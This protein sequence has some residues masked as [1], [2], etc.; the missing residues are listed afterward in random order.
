MEGVSTA[1]WR[2]TTGPPLRSGKTGSQIKTTESP[3]TAMFLVSN[4]RA[5]GP[6]ATEPSRLSLLP[7]HGQWM[8]PSATVDT[9][10]PKCVQVAEKPLNT[11]AEGCVT[12]TSSTITPDPTGTSDVLAMGFAGVGDPGAAAEVVAVWSP[13]AGCLLPLHAAT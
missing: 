10:H 5:A 7:W 6:C 4:G 13:A 1:S 9:V 8:V 3:C 12:T 11:P 2:D